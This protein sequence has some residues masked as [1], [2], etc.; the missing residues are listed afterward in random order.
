MYDTI[1]GLYQCT[2]SRYAL[3]VLTTIE[4]E[5]QPEYSDMD[6]EAVTRWLCKKLRVAGVEGS[7][8]MRQLWVWTQM[9]Q[10]VLLE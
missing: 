3:D 4:E 7:E 2:D 5:G 10:Q 8:M 6:D 1:I 9:V